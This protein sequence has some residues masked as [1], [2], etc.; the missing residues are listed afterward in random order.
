MVGSFLLASGI[1]Y[2]F[3]AKISI[4]ETYFN[5]D[6]SPLWCDAVLILL[7]LALVIPRSIA[8]YQKLFI[9]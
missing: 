9:N 7:G 8:L 5:L 6:N 3:F 1:L 2:T 4:I